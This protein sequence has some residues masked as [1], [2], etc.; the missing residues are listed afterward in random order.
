MRTVSPLITS[1]TTSM[2]AKVTR[3]CVSETANEKNG[4][5]KK[6]SN[7][8][9]LS[10]EANAVGPRPLRAATAT[11]PSRYTMI[12]FDRPKCE[13]MSQAMPVQRATTTSASA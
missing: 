5:T 11:T 10:S 9:T 6:K 13:N 1:A 4:G 8:A 3:Y 2:T 12:K 7:V